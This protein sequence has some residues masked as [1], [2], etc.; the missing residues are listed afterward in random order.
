MT[1]RTLTLLATVLALLSGPALADR[2]YRWVDDEGVTHY[3]KK[4]PEGRPSDEI[5]TGYKP[6]SSQEQEMERLEK[7]R[8]QQRQAREEEAQEQ[9]DET[10]A[11]EEQSE[12]VSEEYC[13]KHRENLEILQNKPTVRRR[14]PETGEMEVIPEQERQK[15]I[16]RTKKELEK[17]E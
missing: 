13:Q 7:M 5:S 15:M 2:Y 16:E 14:N 4:P 8:R 11:G 10:A 9:T 1:I 12:E 6:S 3:T 17:C